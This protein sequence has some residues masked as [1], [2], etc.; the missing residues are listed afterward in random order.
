MTK[1]MGPFRDSRVPSW[2]SGPRTDVPAEHHIYTNQDNNLIT[3]VYSYTIGFLVKLPACNTVNTITM[4]LWPDEG[5]FSR[6][7]L[8]ALNLISTFFI[9]RMVWGYKMCNKEG[10]KVIIIDISR[11][12]TSWIIRVFCVHSFSTDTV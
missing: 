4:R 6:N 9:N 5:Y 7:V 12:H 3:F 8:Y 11:R 1:V 10:Q 2:L